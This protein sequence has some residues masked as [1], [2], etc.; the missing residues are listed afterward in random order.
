VEPPLDSWWCPTAGVTRLGV[1][2]KW[3]RLSTAGGAPPR[4]VSR[5]GV[6]TR[7][8]AQAD[9][10]AR[11]KPGIDVAF[12]LLS[13]GAHRDC[14]DHNVP[15]APA[16]RAPVRPVGLISG[17]V[18]SSSVQ[19][20]IEEQ[21]AAIAEMEAEAPT[22]HDA[23]VALMRAKLRRDE[24]RERMADE[25]EEARARLQMERELQVCRSLPLG[26][27][28]WGI[29]F[30]GLR[31][32]SA[33]RLRHPHR[34]RRRCG[35]HVQAALDVRLGSLRSVY[36]TLTY[37][38]SPSLLTEFAAVKEVSGG[39]RRDGSRETVVGKGLWWEL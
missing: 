14:Q 1:W 8:P 20:A 39:C 27:V 38:V 17:N 9:P 33:S 34:R 10:L 31:F 13:L 23:Q 22:Q 15:N 4:L 21:T 11:G 35:R 29:D 6:W 32:G 25:E 24:L 5:L 18:H 26:L 30:A 16:W 36:A 37:G 2:C 19:E 28:V 12:P 7:P 3:S